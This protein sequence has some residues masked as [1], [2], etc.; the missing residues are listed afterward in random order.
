LSEAGRH[1]SNRNDSYSY[2]YTPFEHSDY[3]AL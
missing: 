2:S 3:F 1:R